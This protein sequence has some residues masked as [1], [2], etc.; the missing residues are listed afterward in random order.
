MAQK[1]ATVCQLL[2]GKLLD[3]QVGFVA[4]FNW[5]AA[6]LHFIKGEADK[7]DKTKKGI[8]VD[9]TIT[10]HPILKLQGVGDD[11]K[12]GPDSNIVF[13]AKVDADGKRTIDIYYV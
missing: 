7:A 9:T 10:D 12:C 2:K 5:M 3:S 13:G 11:L 1:P 6:F 8:I 4:T